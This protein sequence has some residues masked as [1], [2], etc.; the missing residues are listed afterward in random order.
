MNIG[1]SC[2]QYQDFEL[3]YPKA[4]R[5]QKFLC[6]YYTSLVQLC[7][8]SVLFL[9]KSVFSQL[10]SSLTKPFESQFGGFKQYLDSLAMVIRDEIS[11]ASKQ[12]QIDEVNESST[13]RTVATKVSDTIMKELQEMKEWK[14][15]ESITRFF[16]LC[17][18]YD[19]Q[20]AWR[21]ARKYGTT[22]W[23]FSNE[24]YKQWKRSTSSSTLWCTGI[25]GSGKTV[26]SANIVED[27]MLTEP[28]AVVSYFF[29]RHDNVESLKTRTVIGSIARQI[30]EQYETDVAEKHI[31]FDANALDTHT[32]ITC[33]GQILP[34]IPRKNIIVIDG[35]DECSTKEAKSLLNCLKQLQASP[36]V[37]QVYCSCRPDVFRRA[38]AIMKPLFTISV[39]KVN[40][41]IALYI[42]NTLEQRLEAGSLCIRDPKIIITIQDTLLEKA[43]GMWVS[44]R[45]KTRTIA[46]IWQVSMGGF[47]DRFHLFS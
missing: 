32:I 17:S 13:F 11:L 21:Q 4:K 18:V 1:R 7:T 34:P 29:C 45:E 44:T 27:L 2:P 30:L 14:R 35:L 8:Q 9:K 47:S 3:L 5:L 20:R 19:H 31:S 33:L 23:I 46:D 15:R 28:T 16:D 36:H 43:N 38:P 25:L 6:E 41:E 10:S 39:P 40:P 37:F 24:A 22:T 26:L 42:E 12:I